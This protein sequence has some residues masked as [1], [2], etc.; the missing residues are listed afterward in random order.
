MG[1][2]AQDMK[3]ARGQRRHHYYQNGGGADY[4]GCD[5]RRVLAAVGAICKAG[6]AVRFG[7]TRDGGAYAVGVY[8]DG[9]KPYTDYLRPGESLEDYL[10][11]LANTLGGTAAEK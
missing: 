2:S 6:G 5:A 9:D 1:S 10:D 8:G 7:Y 11:D 3:N 4:S